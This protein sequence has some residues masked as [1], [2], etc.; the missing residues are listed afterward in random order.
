MESCFDASKFTIRETILQSWFLEKTEMTHTILCHVVQC[1]KKYQEIINNS[2][3]L[4]SGS[5]S[6]STLSLSVSLVLWYM[7][8]T[9]MMQRWE[10]LL[11]FLKTLQER[12]CTW[13]RNRYT[14]IPTEGLRSQC[15]CWCIVN[16]SYPNIYMDC[17]IHIPS[18]YLVL[19][20]LLHILSLVTA[21][22]IEDLVSNEE[23][24]TKNNN[25]NLK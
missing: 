6:P 20:Y 19:G 8:S 4:N 18:V 14:L 22:A 23:K 11:S 25:H 1:E 5:H 10:P 7:S 17:K 2:Y 13:A 24:K 3:F 12:I 9:M 21:W 16:A 15:I